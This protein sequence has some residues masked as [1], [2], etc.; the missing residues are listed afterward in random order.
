M[1]IHAYFIFL[2]YIFHKCTESVNMTIF[3]CGDL[4]APDNNKNQTNLEASA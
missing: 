3:P 1:V 4:E 2:Q